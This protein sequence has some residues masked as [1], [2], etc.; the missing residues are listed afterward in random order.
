[1]ISV[2]K[3]IDF[4][5]SSFAGIGKS[6]L[7]GSELVSTIAKVGMFN[8]NASVTA[9]CSFLTSIK[10]KAAGKR[11]KSAIPPKSDSNLIRSRWIIKRSFFERIA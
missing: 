10:N 6:M 3:E 8:F 9:M 4:V 2:I 7:E 5:A 1:M 11:F